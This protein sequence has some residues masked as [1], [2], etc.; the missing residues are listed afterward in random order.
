MN[1]RLTKSIRSRRTTLVAAVLFTFCAAPAAA[2]D[3]DDE[4]DGGGGRLVTVGAGVQA[5]PKYPGASDLGINPMPV[6]DLRRPGEPIQFE[7]PD[8]GWGFGL[9]GRDSPIDFGPAIQFQGKRDEDDVGAA[10][11]N[12]GF[13]VEAGAFVE[14]YLGDSFRLRAEGRRGIGGHEGWIGDVGADFI[15]RDGDRT[16]FSIGPRLRLAD[17]N[18]MN[19]YF[20]ISPEARV[21]TGLPLYEPEGG[22]FSVGGTAGL[23]HHFGADGRWG[24]HAYAR[25]DRLVGDAVDS[26]IVTG[27][28]SVNQYSGGIGLSYTFRVGGGR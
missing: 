15:A 12:V 13:T 14:A 21:R 8:E 5:Y 20:G 9:L 26:P 7:A 16:I 1:P 2:Q 17:D 18:Y 24:V 3:R 4:D 19:A 22:V 27:F 25:Y 23:R 10:V 11:G 6:F 28:G